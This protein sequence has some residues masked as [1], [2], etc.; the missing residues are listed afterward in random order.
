MIDC[1]IAAVAWRRRAALLSQDVD[2]D[3][4]AQVIGIDMDDAS[5]RA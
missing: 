2:L 5:L 4:V 1:M 3:R